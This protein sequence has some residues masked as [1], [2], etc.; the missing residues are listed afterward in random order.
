LE[1]WQ[2]YFRKQLTEEEKQLG[3]KANKLRIENYANL[4]KNGNKIWHGKLAG[5]LLADVLEQDFMEAT[6]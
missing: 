2:Q 4:R 1:K 6:V 5:Q 3:E